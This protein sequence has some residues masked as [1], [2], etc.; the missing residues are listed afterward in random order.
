MLR[1]GLR[2]GESGSWLQVGNG[3]ILTSIPRPWGNSRMDGTRGAAVTKKTVPFELS[4]RTIFSNSLRS[5]NA[6][7][8][9]MKV[10]IVSYFVCF[11]SLPGSRR[12]A[13]SSRP[14]YPLYCCE[15]VGCGGGKGKADATKSGSFLVLK[16]ENLALRHEAK[17]WNPSREIAI[18][19]LP[20]VCDTRQPRRCEPTCLTV[21]HSPTFLLP[22]RLRRF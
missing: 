20:A 15:K 16:A 7:Q 11:V 10:Q 3:P 17:V 4:A 1:T 13:L 5:R 18:A 22:L 9:G 6:Y 12:D 21:R 14:S 2:E 19:A 8:G